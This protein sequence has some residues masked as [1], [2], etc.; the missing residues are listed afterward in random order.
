MV[1]TCCWESGQG[2]VRGGFHP[3]ILPHPVSQLHKLVNSAS[4]ADWSDDLWLSQAVFLTVKRHHTISLFC[5]DLIDSEQRQF[6]CK[7]ITGKD[8][9]LICKKHVLFA[10]SV[11]A[12]LEEQSKEELSSTYP[13]ASAIRTPDVRNQVPKARTLMGRKARWTKVW[14][15]WNFYRLERS[16]SLLVQLEQDEWC[17]WRDKSRRFPTS[18]S[19]LCHKDLYCL[20]KERYG[21]WSQSN[22]YEKCPLLAAPLLGPSG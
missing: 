22:R 19:K 5:W 9:E 2:T 20:M 15:V 18:L 6:E 3:F 14:N 21:F 13:T 7:R 4:N 16:E 11:R 1:Y 17:A 8:R 10:I 12:Q